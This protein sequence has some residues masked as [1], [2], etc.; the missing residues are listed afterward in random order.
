MSGKRL[1]ARDLE[2]YFGC[3]PGLQSTNDP[4]RHTCALCAKGFNDQG[5]SVWLSSVFAG[6][7]ACV[8]VLCGECLT[9]DPKRLAQIARE[10]APILREKRPRRGDDEDMNFRWADD[11]ILVADLFERL[12]SLDAIPS[13]TIARKIGVVYRELGKHGPQRARKAA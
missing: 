2:F 11:L 13:G 1:I 5:I 3:F 9:S 7:G 12:E 10:R 8:G 4:E 6:C